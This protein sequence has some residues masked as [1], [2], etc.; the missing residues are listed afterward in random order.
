MLDTVRL[1]L[2]VPGVTS[3]DLYKRG[4]TVVTSIDIHGGDLWAHSEFDGVR[5]SFGAGFAWLSAE[6][7]LPGIVLGD[8]AQLLDWQGCQ[9]GFDMIHNTCEDALGVAL[10]PVNEWRL[11]RCDAVWAWPVNPAPYVGALRFTRL[12]R[13]QARAYGSSVD[14]VTSQGHRT[15]ARF[16]DKACEKGVS[17]DLPSRLERQTRPRKEVVKVQG[18]RLG[19]QVGDLTAD[20]ALGLVSETMTGLG[21][22]K[23]IPTVLGLRGS[24]VD[25]YGRRKGMNLFRALLEARAFGGWAGDLS[26]DTVARYQRDLRGAGIRAVSIEGELPA[27]SLPRVDTNLP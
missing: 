20:V 25:A 10:V 18:D 16:Y 23:P 13:T 19:V 21:L 6:T 14:W 15:R 26:K 17:V 11:T 2:N 8:N 5:L 1:S 4:W 12:P 27:L 3:G 24:L 9:S 7:S 22:D